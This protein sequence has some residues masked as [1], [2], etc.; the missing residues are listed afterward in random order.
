MLSLMTMWP[1]GSSIAGARVKKGEKANMADT[2]LRCSY[3]IANDNGSSM[4]GARV[5]K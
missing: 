4:V 1:Y 2:H 5:E 3:A